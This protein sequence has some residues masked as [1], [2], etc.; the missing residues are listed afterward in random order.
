ML[1]VWGMDDAAK[2]RTLLDLAEAIGL[3]VRRMA[4][5][6]DASHAGGAWVQLK[7]RT[8]LFIDPHATPGENISVAV[9]ALR[10]RPELQEQF[11]PP[12]IRDLL[13]A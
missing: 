3:D 1:K 7:G 10:G 8:I 9:E 13:E 5:R 2:L 4:V 6:R 11:I 12:A